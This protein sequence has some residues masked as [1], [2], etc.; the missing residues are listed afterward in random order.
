MRCV[1]GGR[2]ISFELAELELVFF[3]NLLGMQSIPTS[4]TR[5][6]HPHHAHHKIHQSTE[7]PHMRV[8]TLEMEMAKNYI[9]KNVVISW[10]F[11]PQWL[12]R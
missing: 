7:N 5:S 11:P 1:G 9:S 8:N 6:K 10:S 3:F 2:I 4:P 12:N